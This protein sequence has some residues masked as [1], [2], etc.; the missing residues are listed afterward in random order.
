[1]GR[2]Q[3]GR[4]AGLRDVLAGRDQPRGLGVGPALEL[5][6]LLRPL[7]PGADSVEHRRT[8]SDGSARKQAAGQD[9]VPAGRAVPGVDVGVLRQ[10]FQLGES[11]IRGLVPGERQ[12][13]RDGVQDQL[14][15]LLRARLA[16]GELRPEG[17]EQRPRQSFFRRL[18]GHP[19]ISLP[20]TK[21]AAAAMAPIS[22]VSRPLRSQG[23]PVIQVLAAPAQKR[24]TNVHPTESAK[25]VET[26][27]GRA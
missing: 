21:V 16:L 8:R 23:R 7:R 14:G 3:R 10:P 1:M 5:A 18:R 24:A 25:A 26:S 6:A 12:C 13:R 20:A 19:A 2:D 22:T 11:G 17:A 15:E 9:H 4:A 27:I